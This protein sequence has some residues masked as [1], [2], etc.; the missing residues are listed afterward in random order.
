MPVMLAYK[1]LRPSQILQSERFVSRIIEV[2]KEK[3]VNPF[4]VNIPREKLVNLSSSVALLDQIA[5]EI[6]STRSVGEDGEK[7]CLERLESSEVKFHDPINRR[8]LQLFS[9]SSK[10]VTI[11]ENKKVKSIEVNRNIIGTLLLFSAKSGQAIDLKKAFDTL[12][13]RFHL[14]QPKEMLVGFQAK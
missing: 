5:A 7:F 6:L 2:L 11:E 14:S 3:Y 9:N 13:Q 12:C 1:P 4:D 10:K 8:K